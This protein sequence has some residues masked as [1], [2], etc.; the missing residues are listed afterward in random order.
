M[1]RYN[2]D[3]S[4]SKLLQPKLFVCLSFCILG[5]TAFGY[6]QAQ[7]DSPSPSPSSST[8]PS[9]TKA[10]YDRVKE[11]IARYENQIRDLEN[12]EKTLA[13]QISQFESQI[14]LTQLQIQKTQVE[15]EQLKSEIEKLQFQVDGLE[16]SLEKVSLELAR[17]TVARYQRG[18]VTPLKLFVTSDGFSNMVTK[19]AYASYLQEH[20]RKVLLELKS[21]QD[22][23]EK[24]K[25]ERQQK[26]EQVETKKS[27]LE[28]LQKTLTFQRTAKQ[29]L[30]EVTK[31]DEAKYRQL[32]EAARSKEQQLAK[33]IFRDGKVS[34]SMAIYN[35]SKRGAV[36]RG[37]RIG[38]MGN[39]GAPRCS[40]AAHLH[41]EV[42][43][44]ASISETAVAGDLINPMSYVKSKEVSYFTASNNIDVRSFGAGSWEWP[45]ANPVITQEFGRTAW[46]QRYVSGFH[47][48]FDMV[49]YNNYAINAPEGGT[50]YYAKIACGNP[51]NVA[52]IEHSG[53]VAT[54]YLHLQ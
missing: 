45:L 46:S 41:F 2:C 13:S 26:Q 34:Y 35:L 38:T 9:E 44:K 20:E 42:I 50:L 7:N 22:D 19:Y 30:L 16:I 36:T 40:T 54:L 14:S 31:N 17:R 51:I 6:A 53:G 27:E 29:K 18:E 15:I 24:V 23:V 39:S 37:A 10:E 21:S 33:L 28:K 11:E 3:M 43:E 49:D 12:R 4:I 47:T 8:N 52:I 5:L 48:G 32:L 1:L 25:V